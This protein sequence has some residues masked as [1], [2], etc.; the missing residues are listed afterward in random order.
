MLQTKSIH[1]LYVQY[2]ICRKSC[3]L[4]DNAGKYVT[5]RQATDVNIIRRM[6]I[7]R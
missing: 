5:A 7:T 6:R 3:L 1:T 2:R 4:W